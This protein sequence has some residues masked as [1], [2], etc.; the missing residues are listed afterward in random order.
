[1]GAIIIGA[2]I[3][4]LL[5]NFNILPWTVWNTLSDFWPV[6]LIAIGLKTMA[7][8]NFFLRLAVD[9]F[10]L[11]LVTFII[12]ETAM[13]VRVDFRYFMMNSYPSLPY[14]ENI[15]YPKTHPYMFQPQFYRG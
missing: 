5:N 8:R 11:L 13:A 15:F 6:I 7:G 12:V 9:L 2:G 14:F 4:F 10:V 3:V 1:M